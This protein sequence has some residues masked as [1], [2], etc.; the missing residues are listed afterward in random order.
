VAGW[1]RIPPQVGTASRRV[2][3]TLW[4]LL[5]VVGLWLSD[6]SGILTALHAESPMLGWVLD[7]VL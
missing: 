6:R 1:V 4:V 5:V 2:G 7:F 3:P